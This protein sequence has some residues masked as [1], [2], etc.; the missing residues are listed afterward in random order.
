MWARP[1]DSQT[2]RVLSFELSVVLDILL[3]PESTLVSNR[4]FGQF[5]AM[6]AMP[7]EV[8]LAELLQ[9]I[10][11]RLSRNMLT[12]VDRAGFPSYGFRERLT[13]IHQPHVPQSAHTTLLG[14]CPL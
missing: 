4:P 8:E 1:H 7:S 12:A 14:H 3:A 11:T 10:P 6:R 2:G 13:N 5:L 9:T